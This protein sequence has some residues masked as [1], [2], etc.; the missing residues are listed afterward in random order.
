MND[1]SGITRLEHDVLDESVPVA[2]L[3][4]QVL[5]LGGH[6]SSEPLRKWAQHELKGYSGTETAVPKYRFIAAPVKANIT[7][8]P[9]QYNGREISKWDLPE[10]ARDAVPNQFPILW[11]VAE[12]QATIA[13]SQ[14]EHIRLGTSNTSDLA[15]L[16]THHQRN[17]T[18]NFFLEV[19]SVYWAISV[20][21]LKGILDQVRTQL[22]E[23]VAEIRAAMPPGAQEPTAEAIREAVSSIQITAGDNSPIYVTAP[24]A[25]A[26]HDSTAEIALEATP[27]QRRSRS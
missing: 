21:S 6:A 16:M 20:S 15:R 1:A 14:E 8:G 11:S 25:I 22:T 17:L 23:F 7:S 4:R 3:L 18:G 19:T 27:K 9:A 26:E 10:E 13:A 5:I 24:V 2:S 12:I